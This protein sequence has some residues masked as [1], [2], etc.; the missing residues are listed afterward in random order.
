[1]HPDILREQAPVR[2]PLSRDDTA[3]IRHVDAV[4][5]LLERTDRYPRCP[6]CWRAL[7][8]QGP[9]RLSCPDGHFTIALPTHSPWQTLWNRLKGV[10]GASPGDH[11]HDCEHARS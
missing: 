8:A 11:A 10:V 3:E 2:G 6:Q 5:L 7:V 1:M 4:R 9:K